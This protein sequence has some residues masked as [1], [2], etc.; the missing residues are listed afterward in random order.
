MF[1]NVL[2][3]VN[4]DLRWSTTVIMKIVVGPA[5]DW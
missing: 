3:G 1:A 4:Q 5:Q 2:L